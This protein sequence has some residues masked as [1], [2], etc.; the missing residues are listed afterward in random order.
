MEEG[1]PLLG[2]V[3]YIHLSPVRAGMKRVEEHKD[4]A[5]S[6]Y[7]KY[8]KKVPPAWLSRT[9]FLE[10]LEFPDSVRGMK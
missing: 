2:L 1:R 5:F 9:R 7:P 3:N 8:F 4:Y 10:S 6:S